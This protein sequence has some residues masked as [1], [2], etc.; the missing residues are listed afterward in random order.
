MTKGTL[1]L[2][3]LAGG[4]VFTLTAG[5]M[6][7]AV[8]L[9][10]CLVATAAMMQGLWRGGA[11]LAGLVA[12][13]LLAALL[14]PGLGKAVEGAPAALLGTTGL[15]NRFISIALTGVVIVGAV[16]VP[17]SVVARRF[18]KSRPDL[19]RHNSIAGAVLGAGEGLLLCM[20]V[21]WG[22][23]ALEPIAEGRLAADR[24]AA[25]AEG[26][27]A[28]E[29]P[30]ARGVAAAGRAVR[31]SSLGSIARAS[32]PLA[33]SR[34]LGI[35]ADFAEV[36]RDEAAYEHL[37][38]SAVIGRIRAMPSIT[39]ALDEFHADAELTGLFERDGVTTDTLRAVMDSPTVLRILDTT[40]AAADIEP[41]AEELIAAIADAKTRIGRPPPPR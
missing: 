26:E 36:C 40:T 33:G 19:E 29:S 13:M 18:M 1:A 27:I 38:A 12:G 11:E 30:L 31:E 5:L 4:V 6:G 3:V 22:M 28:Y 17:A 25:E 24:M 35:A 21:L 41:L 37:M 8:P 32:S 14:A 23:L 16:A 39:R 10:V 15:T 7:G 2:I 20:F 34:Y 9:V